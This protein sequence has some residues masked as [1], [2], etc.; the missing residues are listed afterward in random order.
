MK[1]LFLSQGFKIADHP[2]W[3][4]ALRQLQKERFITGFVNLPYRGY[5]AQNGW[6][7]FYQHVVELCGADSFDIVYFQ[8]FHGNDRNSRGVGQCMNSLRK[9]ALMPTII[10]S[11]GDPFSANWMGPHYPLQFQEASSHA[12]ITFST[13]MGRAADKIVGWGGKNIVLS[14]LASCPVRFQMKSVCV[15]THPFDFDVVWIGSCNRS[16]FPNLT[17]RSFIAASQ[18]NRL[19]RALSSHY[20]NR[21]GLFGHNWKGVP[22]WQGPVPFNE[23]QSAFQ[24]GRIVIDALPYSVA[25]YYASNRPF[26]SIISGIPTVMLSVKRLDHILRDQD[27]CYFCSTPDEII[28]TCDRLLSMDPDVLYGRARNAANYVAERHTQYHRMKFKLDTAM[29]YRRNGNHLDVN[30]PFF[31]PEIDLNDEMKHAIRGQ[32]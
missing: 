27:H 17:S 24:R 1:V 22:S 4:Y 11:C 28:A 8:H 13:Q 29:R 7:A 30:F 10:T 12:D 14:P 21:F 18:R 25:D 5:A 16:H 3:D 9:L 26:F 23:Q 31:L 6:T 32:V 2:G 20:Q 15:E 19:V